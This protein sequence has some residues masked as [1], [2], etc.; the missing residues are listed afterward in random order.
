MYQFLLLSSIIILLNKESLKSTIM[1]ALLKILFHLLQAFIIELF[2]VPTFQHVIFIFIK[3]IFPIYYQ[4][5]LHY[6]V[7]DHH[8]FQI[9]VE[10]CIHQCSK[11]FL[12]RLFFSFCLG[13]GTEAYWG[14]AKRYPFWPR[15]LPKAIESLLCFGS[16]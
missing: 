12:P 7:C 9:L 11:G 3:Y 8:M 15:L 16:K 4:N 6:Q 14:E 1:M 10:Y 5:H 13:S 2:L